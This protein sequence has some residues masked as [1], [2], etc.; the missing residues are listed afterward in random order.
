MA[1]YVVVW[2]RVTEYGTYNVTVCIGQTK[3]LRQALTNGF[4]AA[5]VMMRKLQ[6]G[7]I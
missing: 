1:C 5:I 4:T 7:S 3:Y 2:L 6:R